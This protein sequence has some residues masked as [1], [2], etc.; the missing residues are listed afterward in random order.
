MCHIEFVAIFNVVDIFAIVNVAC[1]SRKF[2]NELLI[3]ITVVFGKFIVDEFKFIV[4]VFPRKFKVP[5]VPVSKLQFPVLFINMLANDVEHVI[6]VK[7]GND[8]VLQF[9]EN[10]PENVKKFFDQTT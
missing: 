6:D 5:V 8:N 7:F 10:V 9:K 1:V 3:D 2:A 4:D